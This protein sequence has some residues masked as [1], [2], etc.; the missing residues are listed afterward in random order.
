M[1]N[2][3]DNGNSSTNDEA[4]DSLKGFGEVVKAFREHRGLSREEFAPKVCCSKHTVASVELGRRFPP[5]QFPELADEALDAFGVIK[6]AAKHV[7]RSNPGLATWFLRWAALEREARWLDTYECRLVP[8]LL[9]SEAYARKLFENRIPPLSDEQVTEQL[10]ARQE[11]QRLLTERPNCAFS[12][13]LEEHLFLRRMGGVEVTRGLIDHVLEVGS[14]RN[15]AIQ[16]IPLIREEHCAMDGSM[17]LLETPQLERFA[18]CEG[19]ESGQ[20]ISD[21]KTISTLQM[22]YAKLRS[23]ALTPEDSADLLKR[24]RGAL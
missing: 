5:P 10:T 16:L 24:L 18:Y 22:R 9:Q 14:L 17:Q 7:S 19:Q 23:Q 1:A 8:G 3:N 21:R 15:V 6:R 4:S 2:Y 20:F 11:R 12:F 13:V